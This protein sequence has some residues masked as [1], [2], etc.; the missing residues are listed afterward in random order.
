MGGDHPPKPVSHFETSK[1]FH[2]ECSKAGGKNK[3][4]S[5]LVTLFGSYRYRL[6]C[7]LRVTKRYMRFTF[8]LTKGLNFD[9]LCVNEQPIEQGKEV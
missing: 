5:R 3:N 8:M 4:L 2:V 7:Y 9:E 1:M 6:R